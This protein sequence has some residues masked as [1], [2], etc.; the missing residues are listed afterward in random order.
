MKK[1]KVI[2]LMKGEEMLHVHRK[3][4][5]KPNR[6]ESNISEMFVIGFESFNVHFFSFTSRFGKTI[7]N[8]S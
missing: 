4:F 7:S 1:R 8:S 3:S 6:F 2:L 5:I